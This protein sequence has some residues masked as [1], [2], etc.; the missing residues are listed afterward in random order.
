V[1]LVRWSGGRAVGGRPVL[2]DR[3]E[4]RTLLEDL[5]VMEEL[6]LVDDDDDDDDDDA[7]AEEERTPRAERGAGSLEVLLSRARAAGVGAELIVG[8]SRVVDGLEVEEEADDGMEVAAGSFFE[9]EAVE[10]EEV[11]CDLGTRCQGRDTS[12]WDLLDLLLVE[13]RGSWDEDANADVG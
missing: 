1:V 11:C 13:D 10:D 12:G 6:R 2:E 4:G 3:E 7:L 8:G 9:V 5:V